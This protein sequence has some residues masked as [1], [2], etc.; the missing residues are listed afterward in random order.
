MTILDVLNKGDI[1]KQLVK[2]FYCFKLTIHP[3]R[4]QKYKGLRQNFDG[5]IYEV[6]YCMI[7]GFGF[8]IFVYGSLHQIVDS[9]FQLLC[10]SK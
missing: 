10:I 8:C 2:E 1:K 4:M 7:F 3:N 9:G 6:G 5:Y